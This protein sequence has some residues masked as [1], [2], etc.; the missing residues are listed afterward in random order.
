MR[1]YFFPLEPKKP[2][3]EKKKTPDLRLEELMKWHPSDLTRTRISVI[4]VNFRK[5]LIKGKEFSLSYSSLS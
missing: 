2:R 5:I 4:G 3:S 1:R